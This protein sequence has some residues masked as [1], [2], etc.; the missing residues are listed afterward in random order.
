MAVYLGFAEPVTPSKSPQLQAN[1]N[2]ILKRDFVNNM[3]GQNILILRIKK[4]L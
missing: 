1:S 4:T 3:K 2:V